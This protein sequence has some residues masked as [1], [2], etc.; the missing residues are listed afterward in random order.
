MDHEGAVQAL[1]DGARDAERS[2]DQRGQEADRRQA[3]LTVEL[4]V[5]P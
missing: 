1:L 2:A 3:T 4:G 5:K